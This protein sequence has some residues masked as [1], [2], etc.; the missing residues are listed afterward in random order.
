MLKLSPKNEKRLFGN[1]R[2][3]AMVE[4][5]IIHGEQPVSTI[6][7]TSSF[8]KEGKTHT[9]IALAYALTLSGSNRVLLIDG[10]FR[11]PKIHHFFNCKVQPGFKD[12][13][14][15]EA[16]RIPAPLKTAY[17][18]L[19]VMPLNSKLLPG[20]NTK[21]TDRFVKALKGMAMGYDYIV[22]DGNSIYGASDSVLISKIFDGIILTVECEKTK[23]DVVQQTVKKI[24]QFNG[25]ILG[26][27]LNKRR[28]YLPKF[29][30]KL[31]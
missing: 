10:N 17:P 6:Y 25:N 28:Y 8:D 9:A 18:N 16:D 15:S 3:I 24:E 21:G 23:W 26:I 7:V 13:M 19:Y 20:I 22:L 27:V 11:A 30:Y 4:G 31:I 29:I 1:T 2:E 5:N 14:E 12:A